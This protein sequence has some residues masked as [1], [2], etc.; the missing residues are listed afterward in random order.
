MPETSPFLDPRLSSGRPLDHVGAPDLSLFGNGFRANA[1]DGHGVDW[2]IR[3]A[4]M[5]KVET[6]IGVSGANEGLPQLPDGK[7]LPVMAM[8]DAEKLFK[9][10]VEKTFPGRKVIQGRCAHLTEPQP[11]PS[12]WAA[13][14]ASIARCASAAAASAPIIPA[15]PPRCPRRRTGNLTS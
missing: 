12:N 7:F 9:Q 15:C 4:D 2:P 1:R 14:L 13:T 11:H 10:A 5:A 6:F 3:Y 8:T